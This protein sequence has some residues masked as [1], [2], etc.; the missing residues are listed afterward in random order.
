[1]RPLRTQ[2]KLQFFYE[3]FVKY[4]SSSLGR[5]SV[6]KKNLRSSKV[7]FLA[8]LSSKQKRHCY[9][10]AFQAGAELYSVDLKNAAQF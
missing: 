1:M 9:Q 2:T 10:P 8:E 3:T 6:K 7:Q 5:H 4:Y